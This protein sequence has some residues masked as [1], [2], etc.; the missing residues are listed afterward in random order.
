MATKEEITAEMRDAEERLERLLPGI[1][2]NLEKPLPEGTWTVHDALC[3]LAADANAVP[4]WLERMEAAASG[5]SAIPPGFNF[6]EYIQKN[7]DD[8]KGKPIDE[9][10]KE[11]KDGLKAD[12][13]AIVSL[14]DALLQKQVPNFRGELAPASEMLR[15]TTGRHNLG[16]MDD[17]EKALTP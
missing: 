4:R 15:Y 16:H 2:A 6:D 8:R 5:P 1:V 7:I 12:T 9:V 10:V 3:H 11:I 13:A 14:D 17:I